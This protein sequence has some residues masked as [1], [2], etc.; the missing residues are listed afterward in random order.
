M[1][2]LWPLL[3]ALVALVVGP[4]VLRP[5]GEGAIMRGQDVVV[6]VTP[7]NEAIR[8]EFGRAFREW[9]GRR[10]GRTVTVDFRTPGG[11]SEITRYLVGEYAAAFQNY[12]VRELHRP[13]NAEVESGYMDAKVVLGK[14]AADTPRQAAR[15]AFLAS[16]VSSRMDVFF[17][18]GSF[19]FVRAAGQGML[20][21]C[22]YVRAHGELFGEGNPIPPFVGGEPYY[23]VQGRWIGTAIG[24][25]GIAWNRDQ[26][27]RLGVPEP[28]RWS[29]L[30]DARFFRNLAL[31]NPTQSSAANKAFEMLIQ[32]QMNEAGASEELGWERAMRLL[33]RIGANARYFTDSSAKIS[34]DVEAG[35]AAAGMTIDFYGR[36]QSEAVRRADGSSRIGYVN[37]EGGTSFGVDPIG[38]LRG[39]PHAEVAARF[40]EF[41]L[42]DGQKIWGWKVGTLGGPT[43]HALRRLPIL[44][45]LYAA[46]WREM[47]SDPEVLPYVAARDFTYHE[48]RTGALFG[49]ISF[50]IRVMC[51]DTHEELAGAWRGLIEA[52]A[53]LGHFPAEALAVFEDVSAVD[54]AAARGRI[55]ENTSSSASKITQVQLAKELADTFRKNYRRCRELA[56]AAR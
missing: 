30:A 23:D 21:D 16:A 9:Y 52:R 2:R 11:T 32:Q 10:T 1:T 50:V 13:W 34:L 8:S 48:K 18:G 38:L 51:I 42:G 19:D 15:R 29:D 45:A 25:F 4:L 26:V 55:R 14:A 28:R 36:Y 6:V 35:E 41:V 40:I 54:Y 5:K 24:A 46:E 44:P 22:G 20:V 7:H 47:R 49:A 56:E 17:G 43:Q 33:Q 12:W 53:R 37:A 3:L 39:A 27:A 31:A